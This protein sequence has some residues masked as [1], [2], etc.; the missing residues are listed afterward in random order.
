MSLF[1]KKYIVVLFISAIIY[2]FL[3]I[4][5]KNDANYFNYSFTL[6]ILLSILI[7]LFDDFTDYSKDIINNRVVFKKPLI[8]ILIA[9]IFI[10]STILVI[11]SEMYLLFIVLC[12]LILSLLECK[13]IK[14][15]KALYIPVICISICFYYLG[16]NVSSIILI[17]VLFIGDLF[18][19]FKKG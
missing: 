15:L 4:F 17:F 1:F 13:I 10:I 12:L 3:Y 9:V 7:R 18:L 2:S 14:Y 8:N 19:I 16:F 11:L 5:K 6:S